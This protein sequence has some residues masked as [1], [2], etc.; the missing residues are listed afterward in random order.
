MSHGFLLD[1]S[2]SECCIDDLPRFD[3]R[4]FAVLLTVAG[5]RIALRGT[6]HYVEEPDGGTLRI[7]VDGDSPPE[8]GRPVFVVRG[9]DWD[10]R[11]V[12]DRDYGCEFQLRLDI[13]TV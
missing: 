2:S 10:G 13:A 8:E 3:G 9:S 1:S 4:R 6:A 11:F 7:V 5:G 12:P